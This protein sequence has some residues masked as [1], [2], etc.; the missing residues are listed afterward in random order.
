MQRLY[1]ILKWIWNFI[2]NEE[3]DAKKDFEDYCVFLSQ[4][5]AT[6]AE[7]YYP[8]LSEFTVLE[9]QDVTNY[10]SSI[11]LDNK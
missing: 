2:K 8:Q 5:E 4:N 6:Y 7:F 9:E 1:A 11:A 3:K 10:L